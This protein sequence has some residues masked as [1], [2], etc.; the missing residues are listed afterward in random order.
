MAISAKKDDWVIIPS[1]YS[2]ITINTSEKDTLKTGNW[3]SEKTQNIY[4]E[5]EEMGGAG[6]FYTKDGWIRNEN[7]QLIPC[8]R[9]LKP[10]KRK[11]INLDFLRE[12]R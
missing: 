2:V 6:Y 11:P 8:L 5:L 9:F 4:Q 7:Y 10:L 1:G 12:K 3:V